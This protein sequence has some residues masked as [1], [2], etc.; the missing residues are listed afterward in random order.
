MLL[1]SFYD[2]RLAALQRLD[3]SGC[4]ALSDLGLGFVLQHNSGTL[5]SVA[6]A[7]CPRLVG[8]CL[9]WLGGYIQAVEVAPPFGRRRLRSLDASGCA[10]LRDE[11]LLCLARGKLRRSLKF[12]NLSDT[13]VTHK[14]VDAVVR[15]CPALR[16]L[17]LARC[18]G[19]R[20]WAPLAA[21]GAAPP[22]TATIGGG[23]KEEAE[24]GSS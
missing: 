21:L 13:A 4:A 6:C 10:K 20:D 22:G 11:G 9:G 24:R 23:K 17:A 2:D 3:V 8:K 14:A 5:V 18:P 16:V 12:V 7:R 15:G 1:S 19:V